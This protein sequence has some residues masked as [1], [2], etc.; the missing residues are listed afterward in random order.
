MCT[1]LQMFMFRQYYLNIC[2]HIHACA[3]GKTI[4]LNNHNVSLPSECRLT[5]DNG[6]LVFTTKD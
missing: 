5:I 4:V 6:C 2:K 1:H 3:N